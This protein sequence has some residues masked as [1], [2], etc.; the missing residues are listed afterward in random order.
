MRSL[1]WW[2]A[3]G[4]MGMLGLLALIAG[5]GE[6]A[7]GKVYADVESLTFAPQLVNPTP[8]PTPEAT[9]APVVE[10]SPS[11]T[12]DRT[13]RG[14]RKPAYPHR[15]EMDCVF[16]GLPFHRVETG[17]KLYLKIRQGQFLNKCW[18]EPPNSP[19]EP[20][21]IANWGAPMEATEQRQDESRCNAIWFG[22]EA[23]RDAAASSAC[24]AAY[25]EKWPER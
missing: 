23:T 12:E 8:T 4:Y 3:I 17:A 9:P 13:V 25:Y 6:Q 22:R 5:C 21:E 18:A 16:L 7:S 1:V 24:W 14:P 11:P 20:P 19:S 15:V 2:F 10:P